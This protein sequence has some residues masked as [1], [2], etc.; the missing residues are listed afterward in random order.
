M[1]RTT[2]IVLVA[3]GATL[4]GF[5]LA[6]NATRRTGAEDVPVASVAA[7]PQKVELE[8]REVYGSSSEQVVFT[9]GSLEVTQTG[10]RA[11]VGVENASSIAWEL[12]PGATPDGT[13]GLQLFKT[14]EPDELEKRNKDQTLPAARA[15]T[16]FEPELPSILEPGASWKGV[17][18]ARGALVADS[19]VHVVFGT[20]IAV[21]KP[22]DELDEV[23]VWIT[24]NTYRLRP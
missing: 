4:A 23:L 2:I 12:D 17:M 11:R 3:L 13:F 15:A 5:A 18:S 21:G 14:G 19:W 10:W 7:G 16:L 8:W 20:L 1:S 24:D 6:S 22:P 9:V